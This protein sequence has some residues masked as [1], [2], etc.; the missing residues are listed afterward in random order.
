MS[1]GGTDLLA[2]R[3]RNRIIRLLMKQ[4]M[5]QSQLVRELGIREQA[6]VRHLKSLEDAGL[7]KSWVQ[8]SPDGAPRR[9]YTISDELALLRDLFQELDANAYLIMAETLRCYLEGPEALRQELELL[10]KAEKAV[11]SLL[12]QFDQ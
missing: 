5:Y 10:K 2:N 11:A 12:N 9:Y 3:T 7:L 6:A 4:A 8:P 1:Q